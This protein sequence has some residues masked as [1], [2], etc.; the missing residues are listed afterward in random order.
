MV[1]YLVFHSAHE[2]R[3]YNEEQLERVGDVERWRICGFEEFLAR[4]AAASLLDPVTD[5]FYTWGTGGRIDFVPH[6]FKPVLRFL[7]SP[8]RRLLIADETG[9]GKTIEAG[10]ILKEMEARQRVDSVVVI[11]P[12]ALCYK[13]QQEMRRFGEEFDIADGARLRNML[14]YIQQQG[15]VSPRDARI[16]LPLELARRDEYLVGGKRRL[17]TGLLALDVI[18]TLAIFDEAHHLRHTNTAS[19]ALA[20]AI[21]SRS[22]AALMLTATPIHTSAYDLYNLLNLLCP[23]VVPDPSVYDALSESA[24]PI[25]EAVDILRSQRKDWHQRALKKLE[26]ISHT[27]WGVSVIAH[28]ERFRRLKRLLSQ[29]DVGMEERVE[30]IRHLEELSPFSVLM[31]R[32]RRRDIGDFCLRR[33]YTVPVSLTN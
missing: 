5:F 14:R 31:N 28:T 24:R 16:I 21:C 11:C 4:F 10:L 30:C 1:R 27:S 23:D 9:V 12:K 8:Y 19:Y 7:R 26:E 6:Q 3:E 18:W 17:Q 13:W 20:Q 25:N 2:I 29:K 22:E 32:T 15:V 33:A